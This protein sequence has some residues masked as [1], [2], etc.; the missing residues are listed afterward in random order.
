[1]SVLNRHCTATLF[2]EYFCGV[3][4]EAEAAELTAHLVSCSPCRD[5]AKQ[6]SDALLWT[7]AWLRDSRCEA[8]SYANVI[9]GKSRQRSVTEQS[10]KLGGFHAGTTPMS[11]PEK[12][13]AGHWVLPNLLRLRRGFQAYARGPRYALALATIAICALVWW[14]H[15]QRRKL[16]EKRRFF[17]ALNCSTRG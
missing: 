2:E 11:L 3:M 16:C 10:A 15:V 17:V 13:S 12:P 6:I 7:N 9:E 5:R 4:P 14:S 1:M 8:N